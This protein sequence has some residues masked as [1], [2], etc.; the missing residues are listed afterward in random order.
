[1]IAL[2]LLEAVAGEAER[3]AVRCY[4]PDDLG[5]RRPG[6][7]RAPSCGRGRRSARARLLRWRMMPRS[8]ASKRL[9][10]SSLVRGW[11]S[12]GGRLRHG[13]WLPR[14]RWRRS[15][16]SAAVITAP[17]SK[18]SEHPPQSAHVS[19]SPGSDSR[20]AGRG[21][22]RNRVCFDSSQTSH[23]IGPGGPPASRCARYSRMLALPSTRSLRPRA[24]LAGTCRS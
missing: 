1:M 17:S 5:R 20:C 13:S 16:K 8:R 9:K 14:L 3:L 11:L 24:A 18:P 21:A 2:T 7:A 23:H 4:G 6:R 12:T 15:S 22:S 19:P 10:G